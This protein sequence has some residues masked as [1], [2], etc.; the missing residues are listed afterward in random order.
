MSEYIYVCVYD[1]CMYVYTLTYIY[2][3]VCTYVHKYINAYI[4]SRMC[5]RYIFIYSYMH[6]C[7]IY[8][9]IM[10]CLISH[11]D[12]MLY[13]AGYVSFRKYT[14]HCRAHFQK[15]ICKMIS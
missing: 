3:Y 14:N 13:S 2:I 12:E 1:I 4:Y 11:D 5:L 8:I 7:Y 10:K 9:F 15:G 6:I